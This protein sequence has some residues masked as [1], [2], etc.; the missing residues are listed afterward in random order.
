MADRLRLPFRLPC[1]TPSLG[2]LLQAL[3]GQHDD[4]DDDGDDED[5]LFLLWVPFYK[6][7]WLSIP[8]PMTCVFAEISTPFNSGSR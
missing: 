1:A 4:N 3:L 8:Q 6:L 2:A 7:Y 5:V